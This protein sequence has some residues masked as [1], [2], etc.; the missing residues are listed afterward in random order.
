[1]SRRAPV[2]FSSLERRLLLSAAP[3]PVAMPDDATE[4]VTSLPTTQSTIVEEFDSSTTQEQTARRELVIVDSHVHNL[5]QLVNDLTQ[6]DDRFEVF[7]LAPDEDGVDQISQILATTQ[8]ID[9]VHLLSHGEDGAIRLGDTWLSQ[10]SLDAYAGQIAQWGD[11]LASDADILFYGCDLAGSTSGRTFLESFS[12]LTG[13]DVAAS[14]NDTGHASFGADWELEFTRGTI[15]SGVPFSAAVQSNWE[16]KLATITVDTFDDI[17]DAG[18]GLTSLREAVIAANGGG[19]GDVIDLETIGAGTFHLTIAGVAGAESGDLDISTSVTIR[20]VDANATIIDGSGLGNRVF[21][22]DASATLTGS[23]FTIT[24]G[25]SVDGGA[26]KSSGTLFLTDVVVSGNSATNG[27]GIFTTTSSNTTLER[28]ELSFNEANRG[29]ALFIEGSG[30]NLINTTVSSNHADSGGGGVYINGGNATLVNTTIAFNSAGAGGRGIET[31]AAGTATL[32]NAILHNTGG[33]NLVGSFIDGG[34]NINSDGSESFGTNVDPG[35]DPILRVN[36]GDTRTHALSSTSAARNTGTEAGSPTTDQRGVGRTGG[37]DIGAYEFSALL[38]PTGEQLVNTTTIGEQSTRGNSGAERGSHQAVAVDGAGNTVVVWTD[39][40]ADGDGLGVF[41]QRFDVNGNA[42]GSEFQVNTSNTGDQYDATVAMDDSGRFVIAFTS[43]NGDADLYLRRFNADG[44]AIDASDILINHG[45][46][47]GDQIHA[48]LAVNASGQIVVAWQNDGDGIYARMLEMTTTL[49][50]ADLSS[51]AD[52]QV[53]GSNNSSSP[54]VDINDAARIVFTWEDGGN[55]FG[56]RYDFGNTTALSAKHDLNV[57]FFGETDM[58]VAVQS[59]NDFVIAYRSNVFGFTGIWTRAFN[60]D[61]SG[62]GFAD[63][64]ETGSGQA[65]SISIDANDNYIVTWQNSD[66]SGVGV[67]ARSFDDTADAISATTPI[68]VSTAGTQQFASIAAID[69]QN[70]IVVWSGNGT[71][72]GETDT[73]GVFMRRAGT[74]LLP[75]DIAPDSFSIDDATDTTG[76]VSLGTLTATDAD[77]GETFTYRILGGLDASSFTIGGGGSDE[78]IFDNGVIDHATQASYEVRVEVVDGTNNS[79]N[80]VLTVNVNAPNA[81]PVIGGVAAGQTVDDD[82]TLS[83]F[84]LVTITDAEGDNVSIVV[85]LSDGDDNGAFTAASLG[86]FTKTGVGEYTLTSRSTTAAET[87]LR[88]LEFEP[89]EN[90]VAAGSMVTT[91]LTIEVNDGTDTAMDSITTVNATSVNGAPSLGSGALPDV[92]EDDADPAG[93]TVSTICSGNFSDPDFGASLAGIAVVENNASALVEGAWQYSSDGTTW[94]DIGGVSSANALTIAASSRVRFVPVAGFT[95]SPTTLGVRGLDET[96]AGGFS[97]TPVSENRVTVNASANGG[98]TPISDPSTTISVTVNNNATPTLGGVNSLVLVNDTDTVSPF[99]TVTLNDA[100]SDNVSVVIQLS[101]GD[102]NGAFTAGSLGGFTKTGVGEYTLAST[103]LA[104]AQSALRGLV[105]DPTENQVIVA[106]QVSTTFTLNISDATDTLVDGNSSVSALSINDAPTLGAGSLPA[107]NE[108]DT[109]SSGDTVANAFSGQFGDVD[110]SS[111]FSGIAVVS[112]NANSVSEGVWQYSSDGTTWRDIGTVSDGSALTISVTSRVRFVPAVGFSGSPTALDVRGLDNT[113]FGF[114]TTPTSEN[115]V[116]LNTSSPGGT[117]SIS[118]PATTLSISVTGN[119]APVVGGTATNQPV[120]DDA[121]LTP[122]GSVTL[123]DAENDNVSVVVRLSGGDDNGVFTAASLGSFTKTGAGEYTL[124]S[125]SL[126]AAQTAIRALVF[127]P[128][129]NQ[130]AA[131]SQVI[132][133]FTIDVDDG[134]DLTSDPNSTVVATSINNAPT[135]SAGALSNI[136][137][138]EINSGGDLISAIFSGS[139]ADADTVASLS[140]IAIVGNN[141]NAVSEGV[142]QYSSDGATWR[143]VGTVSDGSA[144]AVAAGS[145]LRFVPVTDFVGAATALDV[146]GLDETFVGGFSTTPTSENRIV[147]DSSLPGGSSTISDPATTVSVTVDDNATPTIGGISATALIDDTGSAVPFS[148]IT[149]SDAESDNVTVVVQLSDGDDNGLFSAGSL[150][151]FTKTGVGQYSLASTSIAA[152]QSAL[153]GLNF[154]PT[155]NQVAVGSQVTTI[156]TVE[157]EDATDALSN[158]GTTVNVRSIN[159]APTLL[160]GSL[161]AINE[162]EV[163][164]SGDSVSDAF[165]GQFSDPDVGASFAG[166]AITGNAADSISEGVWQYSSDGTTWRDVGTVSDTN[167]LVISAGSSVRFVPVIGFTGSPVSLDVRGLDETHAGGFSTTPTSENRILINASSPGATSPVSG[168]TT[169]SI[170]VTDNATPVIGGLAGGLP[171]D[172]N[173]TIT[174]FGSATLSDAENDNV[175]VVVRLS[176]GDANGSFTAA[177]LGSFTKTAPGEYRLASATVAA[178]QSAL[179]ALVFDPTENQTTVGSTVI[180]TFTVEVAD[181][182]DMASDSNTTVI[183]SSINDAPTLGPAVL[184]AIGED[185][186]NGPGETVGTL[187]SGQFADADPGAGFSGVVV[188]GNSANALTEG[189]WQYSSDGTTW[190]DIGTVGTANALAIDTGSRIRFVPVAGFSG[191]PATLDVRGLDETHSG[192]STTPTVENRVTVNATSPGGSSPMSDPATT[193]STSVTNN[194]DPVVGGVVAN[195]PVDD[196]STVTPFSLVT[197]SDPE[198]DNVTVVV[199]LSGGDANG[200]FTAGSLGAFTKTGIGEYTLTSST[201]GA[202]QAALRNLIFQPTENQVAAGSQVSTTF[203]L[204]VSDAT[205]SVLNSV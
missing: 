182:T 156:F 100:E 132:T 7:V 63:A 72:A 120:D 185:D 2:S 130:V 78:L 140:G 6:G 44:S 96:F 180:T 53:D 24:G 116:T 173:A 143:D 176:G 21:D 108:G 127:D 165:S 113:H 142:W 74:S 179:R 91:T 197:V 119:A 126:A 105:F 168:A 147:V 35:L 16:G 175:S 84:S 184:A 77:V 92:D 10:S 149:L 46:T 188:F 99:S 152:A 186:F 9:A 187:F 20:G 169:L 174:P 203:S 56:R 198:G 1:M 102:D 17:V 69:T 45:Q 79:Y 112:N 115:R 68:N 125:T 154:D 155:E 204:Q 150:G 32:T 34:T 39:A 65:P 8:D 86:A 123:T 25:S 205:G 71:Q 36:T 41:A 136:A 101:D 15:E 137:E 57:A 70:F 95:G 87:A 54:S 110:V 76:G 190:R 133:T 192:F 129:E 144:L 183:A 138:D 94:R 160:A 159:D 107:I 200:L 80:E 177:S 29:G 49:P 11:A 42:V 26:I 82:S 178:A 151:G 38:A 171:V 170:S 103:T 135:L 124:A 164:S 122:F 88:G 12:A 172:D 28:V 48:E 181:D 162:D 97:T 33:A 158:S 83:P 85:R 111:S 55:L 73:L 131:G 52:F 121:M 81:A 61:G 89:T 30:Q 27:G 59:D 90:Q 199:Q 75:T 22:L 161:T 14:E 4:A 118:D 191:S 196:T 189:S 18:D 193:I 43:H 157:V 167:A 106:S 153:R 128:T 5:E 31:A 13:A 166:I 202:A 51:Q 98:S 67:F 163:N 40:S 109:N 195:Q 194:A 62:M 23:G 66:A 117:S 146:R 114:S 134:I 19:G 148:G 37:V 139:F 201:P 3:L 60:D 104:A 47:G 50:T 145:R 64:V 93:D 141:A 58:V